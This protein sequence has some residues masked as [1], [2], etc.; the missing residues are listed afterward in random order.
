M[1][2]K[3][4]KTA[5]WEKDFQSCLYAINKYK[6]EFLKEYDPKKKAIQLDVYFYL[7][8]DSFFTGSGTINKRGKDL[9]NL[10]K[11]GNDQIFKW[12]GIDDSQ[13][14]KLSAEKI[15][16]INEASIFYQISLISFPATFS[17]QVL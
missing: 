3:T 2:I 8:R 13:L 11:V 12:L 14:V 4:E 15:P 16:T 10:L 6:D 9:D 7:N 1:R 17:G 5:Q